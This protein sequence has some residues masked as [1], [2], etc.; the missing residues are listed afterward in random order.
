MLMGVNAIEK[1]LWQATADT[2]EAKRLREDA[3]AYLQDFKIDED[4][5]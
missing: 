2:D 4:E 1:A 5:R 3:H